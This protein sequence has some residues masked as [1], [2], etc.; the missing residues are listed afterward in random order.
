VAEELRTAI[1]AT[2]AGGQDMTMSFGVTHR[3]PITASTTR[4]LFASGRRAVNQAKHEGRN[5][6]FTRTVPPCRFS[7]EPALDGDCRRLADGL[8]LAP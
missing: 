2:S 8:R 6:V 5:C 1:A 7:P 3:R 4:Q